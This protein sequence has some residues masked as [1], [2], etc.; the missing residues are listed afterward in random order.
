MPGVVKNGELATLSECVLLSECHYGN[1]SPL[2]LDIDPMLSET[3]AG[4]EKL[5]A[6]IAVH[7]AGGGTLV[8]VN[9]LDKEK[10]LKAYDN[11]ELFPDLIVR[12]TG[13]SAYFLSLSPKLRRIVTDRIIQIR[14]KG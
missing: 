14:Q 10:L 5:Q 2:Q 13:Y 7:L 4:I 3:A 8:N 12:V 9:V 1:S 6:L 11:P